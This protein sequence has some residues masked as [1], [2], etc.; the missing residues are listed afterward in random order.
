M[1]GD[2]VIGGLII[3]GPALEEFVPEG[4]ELMPYDAGLESSDSLT[5][6]E[7]E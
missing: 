1:P 2:V 5:E 4:G 3:N 7:A 6:P